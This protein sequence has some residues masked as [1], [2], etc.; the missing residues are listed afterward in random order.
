ML[1]ER[2]I[3]SPVFNGSLLTMHNIFHAHNN[4]FDCLLTV[5]LI[6]KL[7]ATG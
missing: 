5:V 2:S 7:E 3:S 1:I 6:L 4:R